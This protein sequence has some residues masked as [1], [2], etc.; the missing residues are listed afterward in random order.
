MACRNSWALNISGGLWMWILDAGLH[1]VP[2]AIWHSRVSR[3]MIDKHLIFCPYMWSTCCNTP[4]KC[5]PVKYKVRQKAGFPI[6]TYTTSFWTLDSRRW[7]FDAGLSTPDPRRWSLDAG[8][9]TLDPWHWNQYARSYT[10]DTRF[11]TLDTVVVCFRT[12]SESN[13]RKFFGCESLRTACSVETIGSDVVI[14][15]NSISKLNVML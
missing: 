5:T 1:I 11:C 2:L 9:W 12:G 13:Y 10:L 3:V 6:V 8:P 14:L 4:R 15:R 7:T